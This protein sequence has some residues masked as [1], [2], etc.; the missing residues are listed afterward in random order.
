MAL[1]IGRRCALYRIPPVRVTVPRCNGGREMCLRATARAHEP[2]VTVLASSLSEVR[3]APNMVRPFLEDG[4][5]EQ[6]TTCDKGIDHMA[7]SWSV[8]E[9]LLGNSIVHPRDAREQCQNPRCG[10]L[11]IWPLCSRSESRMLLP[12][13]GPWRPRVTALV[14]S[15]K[16]PGSCMSIVDRRKERDSHGTRSCTDAV[17]LSD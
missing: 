16:P 9:D 7:G 13:S 8:R 2:L 4:N 6:R 5:A 11:P 12:V 14:E 10:N 17:D 1:R 3:F 15:G